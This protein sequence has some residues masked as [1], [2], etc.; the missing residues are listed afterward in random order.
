MGLTHCAPLSPL[1][2]ADDLLPPDLRRLILEFVP[3]PDFLE[4]RD[5]DIHATD[6]PVVVDNMLRAD[7]GRQS[8]VYTLRL[9]SKNIMTF[10]RMKLEHERALKRLLVGLS[11]LKDLEVC[12]GYHT[13]Q[14]WNGIMLAMLRLEVFVVDVNELFSD[15]DVRLHQRIADGLMTSPYLRVFIP[16]SLQTHYPHGHAYNLDVIADAIVARGCWEWLALE[17]VPGGVWRDRCPQATEVTLILRRDC[18]HVDV[19]WDWFC[20]DDD[21]PEGGKLVVSG[22]FG[23]DAFPIDVRPILPSNRYL[24]VELVPPFAYVGCALGLGRLVRMFRAYSVDL[25]LKLDH[26]SKV[27]CDIVRCVRMLQCNGIRFFRISLSDK[28]MVAWS[29][30]ITVLLDGIMFQNDHWNT[31]R[32]S[33]FVP[34]NRSVLFREALTEL[35]LST[36]TTWRDVL[37]SRRV[38]IRDE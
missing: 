2:T 18:T 3:F 32:L 37:R 4:S 25:P 12:C 23:D 7:R 22:D 38:L 10:E 28:C 26:S 9:V 27:M 6:F 30:K 36:D 13:P 33:I 16:G 31:F 19:N 15:T 20:S 5:V 24:L 34:I 35:N 14:L 29:H 1:R 17:I 8:N 11:C 21:M